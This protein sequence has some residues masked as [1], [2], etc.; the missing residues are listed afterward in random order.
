MAVIFQ[1]DI[2][3]PGT[4]GAPFLSRPKIF[5]GNDAVVANLECSIVAD[6]S[7]TWH[8]V[9]SSMRGSSWTTSTT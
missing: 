1:G 9:G 4:E 7:D 2:T 6:A 5:G 3:P 8:E